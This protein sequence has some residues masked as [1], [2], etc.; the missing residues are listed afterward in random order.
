MKEKTSENKWI[1]KIMKQKMNMK[2]NIFKKEHVNKNEWNMKM[3]RRE[4]HMK[5]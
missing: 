4:E 1:W 2:M 5:K 3:K